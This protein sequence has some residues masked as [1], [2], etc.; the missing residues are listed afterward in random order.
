MTAKV[1]KV[2]AQQQAG[3][4]NVYL[5]GQYAFPV[6]E[7][8]LIQYHVFQGQQLT[9]SLI[10]TI[11]LADQQAKL[12]AKAVDFISYQSRT[13]AEVRTKLATLTDDEAAIAQVV[14]RLKQ[15]QLLDDRQ[16]AQ[17]YVQQVVLAGKKGPQAAQRYL[18][19]KGIA[20]ALAQT[21]VA[22]DYPADQALKIAIQLAQKTFDQAR[23]YPYNKRIEKTKLALMRKGFAF[24]TI[25]EALAAIDDTVDADDQARLLAQ[26]G[27]KAW[28]KYRKQPGLIR[29]QKVKQA[30]VRRGF[31][32]DDIDQLIDD[33]KGQQ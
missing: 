13:E 4:Y 22:T 1:T 27:E 6:S 33:I 15:L 12:Y 29:E 26:A 21:A 31:A 11:Q 19:H 2:V 16:Y 24:A 25:D 10:Q 18:Q 9:R 30:L 32:F 8:V 7:E 5:D 20:E 14:D 23:R 28:Y 17:R 3:R